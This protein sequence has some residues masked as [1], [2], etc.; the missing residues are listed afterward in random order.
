MFNV[1]TINTVCQTGGDMTAISLFDRSSWWM[2]FA[3]LIVVGDKSR[4]LFELKS[5]SPNEPI[6][7]RSPKF[8]KLF[9][10][11]S[12]TADLS[13]ELPNI[14]T[15][16]KTTMK[17]RETFSVEILGK[18]RNWA[19]N[20]WSLLP[21]RLRT[22]S[23]GIFGGRV[24]DVTLFSDRSRNSKFFSKDSALTCDSLLLDRSK[25]WQVW[26]S[27]A[28]V[29]PFMFCRI[30]LP[31]DN[32]LT[33][34]RLWN[35]RS[36]MN[37]IS[38]LSRSNLRSLVKFERAEKTAEFNRLRFAENVRKTFTIGVSARYDMSCNWLSSIVRIW[39]LIRSEKAVRDVELS[40]L[41]ERSSSSS[42]LAN[43]ENASLRIIF[44]LFSFNFRLVRLW[45]VLNPNASVSLRSR[46]CPRS[47]VLTDVEPL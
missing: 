9:C 23:F 30:F 15:D 28:N 17:L 22:W 18:R 7:R 10:R 8:N 31:S 45:K 4:K 46:F 20:I 35:T 33:L 38:L 6:K 34:Y 25:C 41:P 1:F 2:Y 14:A 47:N 32:T 39:M 13:F 44:S 26:R 43:G 21:P 36:G 16:G 42:L 29:S 37:S 3:R 27:P 5:T 40:S 19:G 24:T 12:T 11:K